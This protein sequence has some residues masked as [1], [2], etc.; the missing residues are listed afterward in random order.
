I[1]FIVKIR[2]LV[3]I[4]IA[5]VSIMM[6]P[7]FQVTFRCQAIGSLLADKCVFSCRAVHRVHGRQPCQLVLIAF[8]SAQLPADRYSMT[9][10]WSGSLVTRPNDIS[11]GAVASLMEQPMAVSSDS[12]R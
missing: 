9:A 1:H 3:L 8:S 12:I 5:V 7:P 10:S 4:R 6:L 11:S 2:A